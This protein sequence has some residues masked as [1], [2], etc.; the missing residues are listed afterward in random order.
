MEGSSHAIRSFACLMLQWM[1]VIFEKGIEET[2]MTRRKSVKKAKGNFIAKAAVG[3]VAACIIAA[4]IGFAS[5]SLSG[6]DEVSMGLGSSGSIQAHITVSSD[7]TPPDSSAAATAAGVSDSATQHAGGGNDAGSNSNGDASDSDSASSADTESG[8]STSANDANDT[9]V[10]NGSS[11]SASSATATTDAFSAALT[12]RSALNERTPLNASADLQ[13]LSDRIEQQRREE[14]EARRVAE[15]QHIQEIQ[16]KQRAYGGESAVAQVDFSVGEEAFV[17]EWTQ[18]IDAYLAGSNLAGHGCDFAQ[19]AWD[20]G[21]DPRWSPAIS[22]TESGK[23]AHCFL[24]HNAWGWGASIWFNWTD[25]IYDHVKGLA[26]GYGYSITYA[27]AAKYCPPNT[28]N[29]Y[30]NTL[31]EMSKI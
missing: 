23:G 20:Y 31:G 17:E 29:W 19:A 10:S 5:T 7:I 26:D 27:A 6:P 15:Q 3:G 28:A 24:P 13:T 21:V 14:E 1:L 11:S 4:V 8:V 2:H 12:R 16:E 9:V 22:N 25:A 18:R 30:N